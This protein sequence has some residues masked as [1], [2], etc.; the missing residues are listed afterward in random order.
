MPWAVS[1][2]YD[3]PDLK[4]LTEPLLGPVGGGHR[5]PILMVPQ[6]SPGSY[7]SNPGPNNSYQEEPMVPAGWGPNKL[8][9]LV[10]HTLHYPLPYFSHP[11]CYIFCAQ[12]FNLFLC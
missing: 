12:S 10:I 11:H 3:Y 1:E 7:T 9:P 8:V 5:G 4:L 6:V 2:T